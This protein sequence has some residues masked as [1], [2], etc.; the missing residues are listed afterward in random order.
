MLDP[1][2][3]SCGDGPYGLIV[4][5]VTKRYSQFTWKVLKKRQAELRMTL[6]IAA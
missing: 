1:D 2:G 6:I 3:P 4:T 5:M